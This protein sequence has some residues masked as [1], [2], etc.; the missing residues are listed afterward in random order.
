MEESSFWSVGLVAGVVVLVVGG[1]LAGR[2]YASGRDWRPRVQDDRT[3]AEVVRKAARKHRQ[4]AMAVA[5]V[6]SHAV[7][8]S[9]TVGTTVAGGGRPVS[10]ESRFHLGSTTKGLTALL[11]AMLVRDGRLKY[12]GTL[13]EL[14]PEVPMREEYRPVTVRDLLVHRSGILA[15]QQ[16]DEEDPALMSQLWDELPSRLREPR[17]QRIAMA[18]MVLS[19]PPRDPVGTKHVYSNA[20]YCILG[21]IAETVGGAPFEDLIAFRI[22]EPLAMKTARLGGWPA[23]AAEPDQP[24]GHYAESGGPRAQELDDPY[25]FPAWMNPAGGA[26]CS[27][28][29]FALYAREV[30]RG[31]QGKGELLDREGYAEIHAPQ[32]TVR[33]AEMYEPSL[34]ALRAAYGPGVS[35]ATTTIGYGWGVVETRN[36]TLSVGDGSGGTFFARIAV[37]PSIDAAI[38]AVTSSG[39]GSVA[40]ADVVKRVT[41]LTL[42]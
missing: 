10:A 2:A 35:K 9:A 1:L 3:L 38:V 25:T 30:L 8:T 39:S 20:G 7:V 32:A 29:D 37:L 14:L 16:R 15:M 41:G 21:L 11:I 4:P 24:R 34:E 6:R 27:I 40:I 17:D 23:S 28:G 18:K 22:F 33:I 12:E 26:H 36:G 13:G 19:L 31:L 5:L 42:E